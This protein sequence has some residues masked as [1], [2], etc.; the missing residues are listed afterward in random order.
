MGHFLLIS[1]GAFFFLGVFST[2]IRFT[3]YKYFSSINRL[4]YYVK[5]NQLN[6]YQIREFSL[7]YFAEFYLSLTCG[8]V[9]SFWVEDE[10]AFPCR[11]K[12]AAL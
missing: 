6:Y 10:D 5:L 3:L 1:S 4:V 2:R 11:I 9:L 12:G 7:K 8:L